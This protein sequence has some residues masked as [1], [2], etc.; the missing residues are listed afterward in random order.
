MTD[1]EQ[2]LNA[3]EQYYGSGSDQWVE[4]AKYGIASDQAES[5]LSQVPGVNVIKNVNGTIRSYN[6][7]PTEN[8]ASDTIN[9]NTPAVIKSFEVPANTGL[10]TITTPAGETVEQMTFKSGMSQAGNFVFTEVVP[11]IAAAGVGITLGKKFDK[12]LYN[13]DPD[14][15]D[16][17]GMST[18]NSD[19]WGDIIGTDDVGG[20]V[21]NIILGTTPDFRTQAYI[22]EN[23]L[24]YMALYMQKKGVF[25]K[26]ETEI[27]SDEYIIENY[28]EYANAKVYATT[29]EAL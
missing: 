14:F 10:E 19:V 11:A 20:R 2:L 25:A 16:E 1:Y 12:L 21:L 17:R 13:W 24:A 26:T 3:V 7:A 28:P 6:F 23:A 4:I 8:I 22:D 15:W 9:S 27:I 18:L 5:I 29:C